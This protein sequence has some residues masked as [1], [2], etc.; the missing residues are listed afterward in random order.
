MN[1]QS[2]ALA[3]SSCSVGRSASDDAEAICDYLEINETIDAN[4]DHSVL[5]S[6]LSNTIDKTT[7]ELDEKEKQRVRK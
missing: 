7:N 2:I 3:S 6:P 5:C 1:T 4:D